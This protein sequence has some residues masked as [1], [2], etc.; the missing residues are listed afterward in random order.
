MKKRKKK[1]FEIFFKTDTTTKL[2]TPKNIYY[3]YKKISYIFIIIR[4]NVDCLFL[5]LVR[6]FFSI[7]CCY[8]LFF[9]LDKYFDK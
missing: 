7:N 5:Y 8:F 9:F 2:E 3:I 4:L 1:E 6:F